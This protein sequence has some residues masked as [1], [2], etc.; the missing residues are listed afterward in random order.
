M[1]KIKVE[2]DEHTIQMMLLEY[3]KLNARKDCYYFAVPNAAK[4]SIVTAVRM[5][6]EGLTAGVADL[7]I[8]LPAAQVRWLELKRHKGRQSAKQE[9]FEEVCAV[10]GHFYAVAHSFEEA[11]LAL[12]SWDVLRS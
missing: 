5:K 6:E 9:G 3:L 10:L 12:K 4:R 7:C 11:V 2:I 1:T 8:M